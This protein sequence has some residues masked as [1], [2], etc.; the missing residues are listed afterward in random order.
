MGLRINQDT[1]VY[2][3]IFALIA[4]ALYNIYLD[5]GPLHAVFMIIG[6][7]FFVIALIGVI[8]LAQGLAYVVF[9]YRGGKI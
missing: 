6:M 5:Y 3:V 1:I 7:L 4:F 9:K 2:A 8:L